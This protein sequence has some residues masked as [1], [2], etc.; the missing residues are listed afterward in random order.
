MRNAEMW[1]P[2]CERLGDGD[3]EDQEDLVQVQREVV[4]M[5]SRIEVGDDNE[6]KAKRSTRCIKYG[7]CSRRET[8]TV[9]LRSTRAAYSRE[10]H[11]SRSP[12]K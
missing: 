9:N 12:L 1:K 4:R 11:F 6:C 8:Q 10:K 3:Q 7:E 5:S 2:Y